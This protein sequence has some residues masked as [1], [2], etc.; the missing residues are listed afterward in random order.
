MTPCL[1]DLESVSQ[2]T[3]STSSKEVV[4]ENVSINIDELHK[5]QS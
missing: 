3:P 5:G 4:Q 1:L 2:E